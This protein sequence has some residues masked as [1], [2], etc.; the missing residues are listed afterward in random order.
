MFQIVVCPGNPVVLPKCLYLQAEVSMYTQLSNV[1]SSLCT[2]VYS[3]LKIKVGSRSVIYSTIIGFP[4]REM[5]IKFVL[6][7]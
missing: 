5:Y 4:I 7:N 2:Y 3:V 1:I 6:P